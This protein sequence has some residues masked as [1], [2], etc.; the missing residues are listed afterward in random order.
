MTPLFI[1]TGNAGKLKELAELSQVFFTPLSPIRGRAAKN[2]AETEHSFTGNA[3]IKARALYA[4]LMSEESAGDFAVL[5]DDSGLSVDLLGGAPG[6]H[7]A[8]YAGDHVPPIDHINKLLS[9]LAT[10]SLELKERRAHYTCALALIV[11][12]G[13]QKIELTS[14]G[15]CK[16]LIALSSEGE[17]GFGYDPIFFSEV[18]NKTLS[19]VSFESKNRISHRMMAFE[20]LK[21]KWIQSGLG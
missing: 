5:A 6:V 17:S 11:K 7:S 8:R 9:E 4:E 19:Q 20:A 14:E 21:E 15:T 3:L 16:G 10:K 13:A 1:A 2:A 18:F 12:R